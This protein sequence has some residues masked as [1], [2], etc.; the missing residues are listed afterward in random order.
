MDEL[1]GFHR[2]LKYQFNSL[3][4]LQTSESV[5]I[6][7]FFPTTFIV[8]TVSLIKQLINLSLSEVNSF[9]YYI[10]D[11]T[12]VA[13]HT[14][15]HLTLIY[16]AWFFGGFG[17][18]LTLYRSQFDRSLQKWARIGVIF[19]HLDSTQIHPY[20]GLPT[21]VHRIFIHFC[22][23]ALIGAALASFLCVLPSFLIYPTKYLIY[24]IFWLILTVA[25]GSSVVCNGANFLLLFTASA[26]IF[27]R[28]VHE[29][30]L[31]LVDKVAEKCESFQP[32]NSIIKHSVKRLTLILIHQIEEY[33]FW[34]IL[35]Q[36][37]FLSTY[38]AQ[39]ILNYLIFFIDI[40]KFLRISLIIFTFINLA[41]GLSF[42]FLVCT[43]AQHKIHGYC[44]NLRQTLN[45]NISIR[46][47][48]RTL[49]FL[50]NVENRY[51]FVI[52]GA[53]NYS[54]HHFIIIL[55]ENITNLLLLIASLRRQN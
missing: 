22:N 3:N 19:E 18:V 16:F 39:F 6:K 31:I 7:W 35:N 30:T 4:Y 40:P 10:G 20:S 50:E 2:Y 15:K 36:N 53:L 5:Q 26:Y 13:G 28:R 8:I 37:G 51:F 33:K 38:N 1:P 49:I 52:F 43:Y 54:T 29:E 23:G 46:T 24:L 34:V 32:L 42:N 44:S 45:E 9:S 21:I 11:I 48:L 25:A 41:V 55:L 27:G 17:T 47:K 12:L 14:R